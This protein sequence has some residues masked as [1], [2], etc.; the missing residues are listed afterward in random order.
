MKAS[1]KV[2]ETK[3]I[4]LAMVVAGGEGLAQVRDICVDEVVP[5]F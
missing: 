2:E 3:D 4:L 1:I 5:L